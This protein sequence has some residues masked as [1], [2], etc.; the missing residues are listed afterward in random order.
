MTQWAALVSGFGWLFGILPV[1]FFLP[2]LF[3]DGRLPSR[4]WRPLLWFIIATMAFLFLALAFG[5]PTVT[6]STE[7]IEMPNPLYVEA[8]ERITDPRPVFGVLLIGV[9]GLSVA[10]VFVRFR[11]AGGVERQ[12]IKWVAFGFLAAFLRDQRRRDSSVNRRSPALRRWTRLS[13]SCPISIAI[14]VLRFRLY[15]LDIVVRK[16]LLFALL[17]LFAR[18]STW[19]SWSVIGAWLGRGSSILTMLAAVLVAVTFQ[20]VRTRLS[21]LADRLVYGRRAFPYEVLDGILR[22]D[23]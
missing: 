9:F 21:R 1:L 10:S 12:Q 20:P 2:L 7:D 16:T 17:A 4:R 15:D 5:S 11:G 14:V 19:P 23:R 6:G 8:L 18:S 22:A 3:P 13:R